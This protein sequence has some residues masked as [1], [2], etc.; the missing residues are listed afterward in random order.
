MDLGDRRAKLRERF[1]AA[2]LSGLDVVK[3]KLALSVSYYTVT[4]GI[5]STDFTDLSLICEIAAEHSRV[6]SGDQTSL[7]NIVLGSVDI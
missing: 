3:V 4:E 1:C 6:K 5:S 2:Y 7:C